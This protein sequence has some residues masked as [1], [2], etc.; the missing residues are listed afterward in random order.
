MSIIQTLLPA[1]PSDNGNNSSISGE[2]GEDV[3]FLYR[4]PL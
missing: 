2:S 1:L 4:E 3:M